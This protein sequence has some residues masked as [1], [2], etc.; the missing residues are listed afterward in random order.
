MLNHLVSGDL[1]AASTGKQKISRTIQRPAF[2]ETQNSLT[3]TANSAMQQRN[4]VAPPVDI[5]QQQDILQSSEQTNRSKN[6]PIQCTSNRMS[7]T[8]SFT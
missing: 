2:K 4:T 6:E 8:V 1:T 5:N 7:D 3:N